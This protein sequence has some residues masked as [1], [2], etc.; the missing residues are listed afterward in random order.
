MQPSKKR[1]RKVEDIREDYSDFVEK[2]KPKKTTDDCYTPDEV[3]SVVLAYVMERCPE[4]RSLRVM[5]PF[6]PGG[7][8]EAEDYTGAV[9]IDNPPFSILSK[10]KQ[11]YIERGIPFFLFAPSLTL[12]GGD[13]R[14]SRIVTHADVV[15]ANGAKVKTSFVSNLFGTRSVIVDGCL[16][17][18]IEQAQEEQRAEK[19]ITLP[20]YKYPAHVTSSALL[21]TLCVDGVYLEIDESECERVCVLDSQRPLGKTIFGSGLLLSDSVVERIKAERI[22]A[23]RIKAERECVEWELSE[24]EREI[25]KRLSNGKE[26][27]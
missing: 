1:G 26:N 7:D 17:T 11:F 21:G 24:R 22:K 16:R 4:V 25:I 8:Y 27:E 9:V 23:E 6:K 14:C 3:Y 2:F 20:K 12:F 19:S 5:R 18:R 10:I 15:Y 13:D